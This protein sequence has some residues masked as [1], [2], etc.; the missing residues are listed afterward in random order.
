MSSVAPILRIEVEGVKHAILQHLDAGR[1]QFNEI[2][3]DEL[4]KIDIEAV[5]RAELRSR[6]GYIVQEAVSKACDQIGETIARDARAELSPIVRE[7]FSKA[8]REAAG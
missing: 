1:E 5:I 8:V 7:A 4:D 3:A 6:L 2:V